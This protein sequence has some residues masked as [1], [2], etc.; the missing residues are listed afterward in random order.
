MAP[1]CVHP[2]AGLPDITEQQLHHRCAADHLGALGVLRPP[3]RV[4][5]GH[6]A[7]GCR[8]LGDH[9]AD[10]EEVLH[11]CAR[12]VAH[13][14]GGV[15][16]VMLPQQIEHAARVGERWIRAHVTVRT[17]LV[18]PRAPIVLALLRL[19]AGEQSILEIEVLSHDKRGV[20]IRLDVLVMD[21][22]V[23]N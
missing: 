11:R 21:L 13:H 5:D 22:I 1:Q 10:P 17:Q 9:L 23:A 12:D 7:I 3:E 20:R 15:A 6:R 2:A 8:S 4:H 14:F 18:H 16:C 19:I